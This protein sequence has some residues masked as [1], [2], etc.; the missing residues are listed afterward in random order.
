[1]PFGRMSST[2]VLLVCLGCAASTDLDGGFGP[3]EIQVDGAVE[4]RAETK[5][6]LD[7]AGWL[8]TVVYLRATRLGGATIHYSGCPVTV[9]VYTD[10][11][12]TG[13]PSWDAL[14]V[15]N[16]ACQSPLIVRHLSRGGELALNALTLSRA[17]LGDSL[18]PG[19][20]YLGT[21]VRPN[22]DS[23]VVEAGEADLMP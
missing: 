7:A 18:A 8:S 12:R 10:P 13:P 23:L 1:M 3:A 15:P 9:R 19:R 17:V 20:Y 4:Y 5:P 11:A 21:V 16:T 2:T 14:A 6:S 22:G